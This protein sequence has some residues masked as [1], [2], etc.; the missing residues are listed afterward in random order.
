MIF[1]LATIE[2]VEGTRDRFLEEFSKIVPL[3]RQEVGC[4]EYGP[5]I[6]VV[7]D[8]P[9][10]LPLRSDVVTV[11]EKWESLPA[12]KAHLTAPHMQ[13]YRPKV[14]DFVKQTKLQILEPCE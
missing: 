4:L 8:I 9:A 10:Q 14:K 13:A 2:L 12:L 1:V 11:V 7:T 3:V 6:D 5:T